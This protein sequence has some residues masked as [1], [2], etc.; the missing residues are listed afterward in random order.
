MFSNW[1]IY[2]FP[3]FPKTY[4]LWKKKFN[5]FRIETINLENIYNNAHMTCISFPSATIAPKG[6]D[7]E[8]EGKREQRE[9]ERDGH[10]MT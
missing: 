3:R 9:R 10:D 8:K 6:K 5:N 2:L 4:Q 1:A 7:K